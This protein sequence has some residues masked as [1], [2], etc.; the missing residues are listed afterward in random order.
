MVK[1]IVDST[2]D[3]PEDLIIKNNISII[4]LKVLI[5]DKDY[6]DKK[7]INVDEVYSAMR[8]GILPKTS[9][10]NPKDMY[11]TF[12]E[13]CHKGE[14]FIFLSFSSALSG[15]YKLAK[16]IVLELKERYPKINMEVID[17]KS[18]STA[19]GLIILEAIKFT[20][21]SGYDFNEIVGR[22]RRLVTHIEHVFTITDLNWLIKGGR[23]GKTQGVIGNILE[24]KPILNVN[25]GEMELIQKVRG[26]KKALH[27]MVDILEERAGNYKE[28]II[29][30]SH[31]D[32][33][34]TAEELVNMIK[35]KL[36]YKQFIINKIGS[37]LGSHLGIGGVGI[38]FFNEEGLD[39][40][41]N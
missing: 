11:D 19:I 8:R 33:F 23:I 5:D 25:N 21:E 10:P 28:Q 41:S 30:V 13:C 6:L 18:G 37:V 32:D 39:K 31:A 4:P 17:S 7:T 29:G 12:E 15:T 38:F 9:Q 40:R 2:C 24:I 16:T 36:G 1:F 3:L 35:I 20:Q 22:I 27:R 14:D 34:E 26:K